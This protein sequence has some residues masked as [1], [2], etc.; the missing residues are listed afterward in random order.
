MSSKLQYN[1]CIFVEKSDKMINTVAVYCASSTKIKSC[2]FKAAERLG[3]IFAMNHIRCCNGAGNMGLMAA[4]SNAVLA[5]GGKVTGVIPR[6]MCEQGWQ[7]KGLTDLEIVDTM[8]ERKLRMMQLSDAAVALP[9]GCG[10]L[11]EL[12]EVITW[13]QLGLYL[14]PI[15]IVN[16][17][18]FYTPL[19]NYLEQLIDGQFMRPIHRD[20]WTVIDSPED[21]MQAFKGAKPW[22]AGVRKNAAI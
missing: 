2:Y 1:C 6:F 10:T 12:F 13:K 17:E 19:L 11:E 20:I 15:V 22:D 21:I 3:E 16:V 18:N 7:H 14:K 5:N 8:H 9:G 4:V